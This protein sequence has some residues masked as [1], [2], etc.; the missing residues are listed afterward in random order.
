MD[1]LRFHPGIPYRVSHSLRQSLPII[2]TS[3]PEIVESSATFFYNIDLSGTVTLLKCT[4]LERGPLECGSSSLLIIR[5]V[6]KGSHI[7]MIGQ[8]ARKGMSITGIRARWLFDIANG[9]LEAL[10]LLIIIFRYYSL[11]N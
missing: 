6:C 3:T 7:I 10:L 1:V 4:I 8:K 11:V 9:P 2:F 5:A